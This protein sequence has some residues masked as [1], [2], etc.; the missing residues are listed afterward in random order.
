VFVVRQ[1]VSLSDIVKMI[2]SR[3]MGLVGKV[4]CTEK[5]KVET[6]LS[7]ENC[8]IQQRTRVW[9]GLKVLVWLNQ[10]HL[11]SLVIE[12]MNPQVRKIMK[13]LTG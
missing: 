6:K 1:W 8:K 4:E 10:L 7:L 3:N 5:G 13:W 11:V 2:I 12:E 9:G